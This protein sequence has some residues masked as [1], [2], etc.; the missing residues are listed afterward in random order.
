[1]V[2]ALEIMKTRER[3]MAV[4]MDIISSLSNGFTEPKLVLIGG[5]ALRA[6]VPFSRYTRDCDFI[7]EKKN[8]WHIGDIQGWFPDDVFIESFEKRD[9]YGFL[10]CIKLYELGGKKVKI[11]IDFMEGQVVGR[12]EDQVVT[13]DEK[14]VQ[15]CSKADVR[16]GEKEF[17]F[18]IPD[19][20]DY[21]ILKIVSARPSD[22]RDIAALVWRNGIPVDIGERVEELLPSPGV[23]RK[24]MEEIIIPDIS[25]KRFV[26]SWRGTFVTSEFDEDIKKEVLKRINTL[27][28]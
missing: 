2:S 23:F 10:R 3:K 7:L 28:G 27:F 5:Y 15:S 22:V 24:N 25:D 16:I 11:S 9:M 18:F 4:L 17:S 20:M 1:L 13:I 12:S 14:L 8:G 21:L 19:Y 6:Y 26:N